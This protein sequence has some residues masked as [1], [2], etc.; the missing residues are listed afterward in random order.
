MTRDIQQRPGRVTEALS[1]VF[2]DDDHTH[3]TSRRR[4]PLYTTL[5][6]WRHGTPEQRQRVADACHNA[7]V[8]AARNKA[9]LHRH[10][11]LENRF[12]QLLGMERIE[13]WGGYVPPK[14]ASGAHGPMLN[15][16]WRRQT[17]VELLTIASEREAEQ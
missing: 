1:K 16:S 9:L 15:I 8:R 13:Q 7:A 12:V 4:Q 3:R 5:S 6:F 14:Y 10:P 11:D 2:S 17:M